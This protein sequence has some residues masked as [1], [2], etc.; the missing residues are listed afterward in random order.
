MSSLRFKLPLLAVLWL[1]CQV[2][3]LAVAPLSLALAES[4]TAGTCECPGGMAGQACPMHRSPN[5]EAGAEGGGA[6]RSTCSPDDAILLSL[7]MGL[8][9]L[10]PLTGAASAIVVV[11]VPASPSCS[12]H[13][14]V[15]PDPIPPRP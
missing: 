3:A 2:S 6:M 5:R 10:S 12:I 4:T 8:G 13:R 9:V 1:A 11:D 7:G 15:P 14:V